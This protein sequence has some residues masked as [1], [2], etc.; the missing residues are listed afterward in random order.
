M[1][2]PDKYKE[3]AKQLKLLVNEGKLS[4]SELVK[5]I[6]NVAFITEI[7]SPTWREKLMMRLRILTEEQFWQLSYQRKDIQRFFSV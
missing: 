7:P 1:N 5:V 6:D 4:D 3:I 2:K